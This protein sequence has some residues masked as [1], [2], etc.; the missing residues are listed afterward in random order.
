MHREYL[1]NMVMRGRNLPVHERAV[2]DELV[3]AP[4]APILFLL[5]GVEP[6]GLP[7]VNV[8]GVQSSGVCTH[9]RTHLL[10]ILF[11]ATAPKP[12]AKTLK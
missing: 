7:S 11:S 2:Y 5:H 9:I 3:K 4:T 12:T 8:G 10:F 1:G 6:G